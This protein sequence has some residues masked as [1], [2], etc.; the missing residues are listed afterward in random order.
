MSPYLVGI[1]I[2]GIVRGDVGV[3]LNCNSDLSPPEADN[4]ETQPP[5]DT[6]TEDFFALY[7][8][9]HHFDFNN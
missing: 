5:T 7:P 3:W 1:P 8:G 4:T 2:W 6:P 9:D